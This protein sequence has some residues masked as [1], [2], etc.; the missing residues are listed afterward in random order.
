MV[1][2]RDIFI[3]YVISF[4]SLIDFEYYK[5]THTHTYIYIYIYNASTICIHINKLI[6]HDHNI[7]QILEKF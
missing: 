1:N 3:S 2:S 5:Q 4:E 6:L 7:P